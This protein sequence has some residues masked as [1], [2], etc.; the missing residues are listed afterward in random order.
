ML[1]PI[2]GSTLAESTSDFFR[3]CERARPGSAANSI[4]AHVPTINR[5]GFDMTTPA[6]RAEKRRRHNAWGS[7]RRADA[8]LNDQIGLQGPR[9]LDRL[10]NGDDA[11]RLEADPIEPRNERSQARAA[12]NGDLAALLGD[13]DLGLRR[14]R[15][16]AFGECIGLGDLRR[17]GHAHGE[18]AMGDG[19][20]RYLDVLADHHRPAA[21]VDDD[22]GDR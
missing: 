15:R 17:L 11:A 16:Y 2:S 18:R 8:L 21:R 3:S 14:D 19:D 4:A 1:S 13:I 22:F 6:R 12:D 9:R 10:K 5:L 7:L 20:R